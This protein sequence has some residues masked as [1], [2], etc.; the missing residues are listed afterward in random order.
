MKRPEIRFLTAGLFCFLY[1]SAVAQVHPEYKLSSKDTSLLQS[2]T[3]AIIL[4]E[5][6]QVRFRS[7]GRVDLIVRKATM[8]LGPESGMDQ[9][10]VYY[11][12]DSKVSYFRGRTYDSSGFLVREVE[13][14][15]V[16][17]GATSAYSATIGDTRYKLIEFYSDT[18]PYTIE[19]EYEVRM[20]GFSKV[21][22]FDWD[23]LPRFGVALKQ[24]VLEVRVP[25]DF[26]L[27]FLPVNVGETPGKTTEGKEDVYT[28]ALTQIPAV[29][30]EQEGPPYQDVLP[31][32]WILPS[33]FWI[34]G[35]KGSLESWDQYG[36]FLHQLTIGRD[37]LPGDLKKSIHGL[38]DN[39]AKDRE[40]I[41]LL[42]QYM[43]S[44]M[45]YV[46]IQLGIGG[47][48]PLSAE[49]VSEHKYGD[50]KALTNYMG[51]MLK[52]VGIESYPVVIYRGSR[53]RFSLDDFRPS[54]NSF[55]HML[56]YV[57]GENCFLECTSSNYPSG[58]IGDDNENRRAL[59][60]TETGGRLID[61]PVSDAS[62]NRELRQIEIKLAQDGK[63]SIEFQATFNGSRHQYYR[64]IKN[65]LT[66]EEQ[67]KEIQE[68]LDLPAYKVNNWTLDADERKA[69]ANL[70]LRLEVP[71]F[72]AVAGK[73]IF[74][75]MSSFGALEGVPEE[76][77]DRK[78]PV[79]IRGAFQ[80]RDEVV[81][82]LPAGYE[83]E[84]LPQAENALET[85]FG[86]FRWQIQQSE[87]QVKL[88]REISI[89]VTEIP[90]ADYEIYRQFF[91]EV[92]QLE[93]EQ[94]VLVRK[95]P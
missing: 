35:Y 58:F 89:L 43:Q 13:S 72:A 91:I 4:Q 76:N 8:I 86:S 21:N 57:P 75:P 73:R 36:L 6:R 16:Q 33:E 28:L 1:A 3:N 32:L 40:K 7:G 20:D 54:I 39:V 27:F 23:I 93:K 90:A 83:V 14:K 78:R 51:A 69:Q 95:G 66:E 87:G 80:E 42:Y 18:Y 77:A 85:S 94:L 15:D 81:F 61:M 29:Q 55:N 67:L 17:D 49:F 59:L 9:E 2:G 26:P 11:D 19:V 22:A 60:V 50:C 62:A 68:N 74:V 10:V 84:A 5:E 37:K 65:H 71:R 48:Q 38:V 47:W 46:S 12:P 64:W 92:S 30:Y 24:G 63:A 82:I 79:I 52:E 41:D 25:V 45:R 56:L 31:R 88:I 34:D 53:P 70:G 44:E